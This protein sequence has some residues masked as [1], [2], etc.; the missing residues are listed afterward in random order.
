MVDHIDSLCDK[1]FNC[2]ASDTDHTLDS[3]L[4]PLYKNKR[5]NLRNHRPYDMPHVR[6]KRLKKSF[7]LAM[8]AKQIEFYVELVYRAR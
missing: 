2:I 7:I 8:A 5:Y 3:L 4:P 1:L 6:T